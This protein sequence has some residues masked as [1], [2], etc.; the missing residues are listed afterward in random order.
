[1]KGEKKVFVKKIILF[2]KVFGWET[3]ISCWQSVS[4]EKIIIL[5]KIYSF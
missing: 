3:S 4:S 5:K 2:E 1:M